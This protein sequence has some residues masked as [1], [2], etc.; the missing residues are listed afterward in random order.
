MT[1]KL[2]DEKIMREGAAIHE[3]GHAVMTMCLRGII[4]Q[5]KSTSVGTVARASSCPKMTWQ[6]ANASSS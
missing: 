4:N 2:F 6:N 1:K 3:A 5:S